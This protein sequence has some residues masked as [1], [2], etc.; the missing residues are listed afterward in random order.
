MN[1][2]ELPVPTATSLAIEGGLEL[3]R[4]IILGAILNHFEVNLQI[5]ELGKSFISEY[6]EASATIGA[7]IEVSLPGG[8]VIKSRAIGVSDA[9]ELLLESGEA[10]TVGDVVHLR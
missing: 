5:W 7:N 2:S 9:G 8:K 6:K 3:D 4:N 1:E 10:V